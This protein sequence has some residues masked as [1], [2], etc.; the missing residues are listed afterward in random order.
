MPS[1]SFHDN[2]VFP[3]GSSQISIEELIPLPKI[4]PTVGKK[5]RSQKSEILTSTPVKEDMRLKQAAKP[6]KRKEL[7][8]TKVSRSK[9]ETNLIYPKPP[10]LDDPDPGEENVPCLICQDIYGNSRSGESWVRCN[11][12]SDW[13]HQLCT[14]YSGAGIYICDNCK[15]EILNSRKQK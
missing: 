11:I 9:K 10:P 12:C 5:H 1:C 15:T 8:S 2:P 13:A 7:Q 14:D 6:T 4:Q 3:S